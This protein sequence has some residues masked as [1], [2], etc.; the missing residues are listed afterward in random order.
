M[1][2]YPNRSGRLNGGEPHRAVRNIYRL[3]HIVEDDPNDL[4]EIP[5]RHDSKIITLDAQHRQTEQI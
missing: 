3:L 2:L 5:E 1:N 4:P